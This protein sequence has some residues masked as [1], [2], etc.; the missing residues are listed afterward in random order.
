MKAE[1]Y[2]NKIHNQENMNFIIVRPPY[3]YGPWNYIYRESYCF[4]RADEN[5]EI[6]IPNDG[7]QKIQF[8]HVDDLCNSIIALVK[9][10]DSYNQSYNIGKETL[11]FKEWAELCVNSTGK[12]AQIVFCDYKK[13]NL[14]ARDFFPFYDYNNVLTTNKIQKYYNPQIDI[15]FALSNCYNWY[16]ENK[17]YIDYRKYEEVEKLIM[18]KKM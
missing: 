9:N 5:R 14:K 7:N 16:K 1:E 12:E 4:K 10:K 13:L 11:T 2:I 18:N 15:E 6:I 17:D 8:I 3:V